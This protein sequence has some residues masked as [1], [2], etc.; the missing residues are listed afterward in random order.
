MVDKTHR[1]AF[2]WLDEEEYRDGVYVKDL[3]ATL[4]E[5]TQ[6]VGVESDFN[7][8]RKKM[9]LRSGWFPELS[10]VQMIP[11]IND[12]EL[13]DPNEPVMHWNNIPVFVD[14][15]LPSNR[16]GWIMATEG[17]GKGI[18]ETASVGADGGAES[19]FES[20]SIYDKKPDTPY[21]HAGPDGIDEGYIQIIN[22]KPPTIEEVHDCIQ[23]SMN[24]K[25]QPQL[26][27][28]PENFYND[29]RKV[30]DKCWNDY[31]EKHHSKCECGSD[32]VGNLF[33]ANYCPKHKGDNNV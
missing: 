16:V 10:E 27:C 2:T 11:D 29:Y 5:D 14:N 20:V 18:E 3:V 8:L 22:N 30:L 13:K 6:I 7:S 4:P 28:M 26:M 25:F 32:A 15:N 24:K 19:G 9:L 12:I 23:Y 33:H 31:K 1:L 21:C 17:V